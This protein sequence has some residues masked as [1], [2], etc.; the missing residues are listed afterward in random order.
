MSGHHG[1]HPLGNAASDVQAAGREH[2]EDEIAGLCAQDGD[3]HVQRR[4]T[5]G[6]GVRP[7]ETGGHDASGSDPRRWRAS[8]R[9]AGDS[10]V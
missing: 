10:G 2:G 6:V 8:P 9:T 3:E 5:E 1:E 4:Q 7:G